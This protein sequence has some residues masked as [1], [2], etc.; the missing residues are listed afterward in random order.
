MGCDYY[1]RTE[2][3]IEFYDK[4]NKHCCIYTNMKFKKGYIFSNLNKDS[5]DDKETQGNK[6]QAELE[7]IIKENTK[8]KILF[9]NDVWI[10]ES[11]RKKYHIYLMK[12]FIQIHKLKKVYKKTSVRE[13]T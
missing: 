9:E 4:D 5:D 2:L 1:I 6:F 3:I 13:I 11:Y 7:R 10:K 12:T 8:N